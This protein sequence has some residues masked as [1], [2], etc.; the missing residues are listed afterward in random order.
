M[1][2]MLKHVV[3]RIVSF[4]L[5]A[6]GLFFMIDAFVPRSIPESWAIHCIEFAAGVLGWLSGRALGRLSHRKG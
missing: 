4:V 6:V 2:F 5:Q 1:S 3:P